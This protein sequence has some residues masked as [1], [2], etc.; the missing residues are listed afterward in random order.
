[1]RIRNVRLADTRT[2]TMSIPAGD[3][4]DWADLASELGL[5]T[6]PTPKPRYAAEPAGFAAQQTPGEPL[7]FPA[8]PWPQDPAPHATP[9]PFGFASEFADLPDAIELHD[10]ADTLIDSTLAGEEFAPED[11]E[12]SETHEGAEGD[13]TPGT[14]KKRRRRRRRKK[15]GP[16]GETGENGEMAEGADLDPECEV[17]P[18][19]PV[20]PRT[21]ADAIR[22][23]VKSWNVPGWNEVVGGLYR[24][25]GGD[26]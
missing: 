20:E 8:V 21:T 23:L 6:K 13:G 11:G 18:V 25:G 3:D 2:N 17:E 4:S 19:V 26:R 10:D 1:M 22:D 15:S 12:G 7:P 24:P 5:E 16:S 9:E 14:G